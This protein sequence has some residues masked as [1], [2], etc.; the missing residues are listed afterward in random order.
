MR[1]DEETKLQPNLQLCLDFIDQALASGGG[2]LVH[3][4]LPACFFH[5]EKTGSW[6]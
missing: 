6:P 2:V 3:W 4:Y 1:D 5:G